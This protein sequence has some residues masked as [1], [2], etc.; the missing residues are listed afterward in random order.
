MPH[1]AEVDLLVLELFH[2]D[3]LGKSGNALHERVLDRLPDPPRERKEGG[4]REGLIAKEQ[5]EVL[6]PRR[7]DFRD[8]T[9]SEGAKVDAA[10][11]GAERARDALHLHEPFFTPALA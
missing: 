1:A 8:F 9:I 7:A 2:L 11:L 6:E 5:D 4:R 10:H 3:D